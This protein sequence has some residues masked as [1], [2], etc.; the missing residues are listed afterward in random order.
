MQFPTA[1]LSKP[2]NGQVV[3]RNDV[4]LQGYIEVAF[5]DPNGVGLN[6]ATITDDA[7]EFEVTLNGQ[8][9][10]GLSINGKPT[11]VL[12]KINTYRYAFTGIFPQ[13]GEVTIKFLAGP[14][15]DSNGNTNFIAS[16][17]FN[18]VN[19]TAAGR[20][21]LTATARPPTARPTGATT[22]RRAAER[23]E[24]HRRHLPHPQ[25]HADQPEQHRR[26]RVYAG[27]ARASATSRRWPTAAPTSSACRS[28]ISGTTYRYYL[29]DRDTT[30]TIGLFLRARSTSTSGPAPSRRSTARSTTPGRSGSRSPP[31][32]TAG[33]RPRTASRSGRSR[34]SAR[35]SAS[36]SSGSRTAWSS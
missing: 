30:N 35:T 34:W 6:A 31:R 23:Q 36:P 7:Q 14:F 8:P 28:S 11:K 10:S 17:T 15:A 21:C 24:L 2:F 20:P 3:D 22:E 32:P 16:Q 4:N 13:T 26:R 5:S 19:R 12:D 29:K 27:P 33:P 18:L 1:D 25:R 9:V